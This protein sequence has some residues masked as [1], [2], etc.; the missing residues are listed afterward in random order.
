MNIVYKESTLN[1]SY[2]TWDHEIG[3]I[4]P[5]VLQ[6]EQYYKYC[7]VNNNKTINVQTNT[8]SKVL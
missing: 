1:Y 5:N 2:K 4:L 8:I 6:L 3:G 7:Y